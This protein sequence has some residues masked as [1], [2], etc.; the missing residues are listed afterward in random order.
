MIWQSRLL[1]SAEYGIRAILQHNTA[2]YK[3]ICVTF[4]V[5]VVRKMLLIL[6]NW[7]KSI[8]LDK[9]DNLFDRL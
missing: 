9:Q 7:R 8:P 4:I 2:R 6:L 5:H 1:K 3:I